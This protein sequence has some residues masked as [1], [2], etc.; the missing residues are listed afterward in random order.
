MHGKLWI[1]LTSLALVMAT[2]VSGCETYGGSAAAGALTGAGVGAIIG[3]Q[4]KG[5]AGEGAAIGAALG[6]L[7]GLIVHDVKVHKQRDAQQTQQAYSYTP[8]QGEV[9]QFEDAKVVPGNAQ[10]GT[11]VEATIQYAMMGTKGSGVNVVETRTL[12]RGNEVIAQLAS[13]QFTRP[14]GTWVS[15]LPFLV[16][17]TLEPGEYTVEQIVQTNIS[18]ISGNAKFQV[19]Y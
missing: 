19:T 3:N 9:L 12:K 5:R 7:T 18:R 1:G 8:E 13:K 17:E 10:R 15:T 4:S 2:V 11:R 16:P 6:A 14:D